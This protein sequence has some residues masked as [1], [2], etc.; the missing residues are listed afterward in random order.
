MLLAATG[1]VLR[2]ACV[3]ALA[4]AAEHESAL[5]AAATA[6]AWVQRLTLVTAFVAVTRWR[7]E[8]TMRAALVLPPLA[9]MAHHAGGQ[10]VLA[11]LHDWP[12]V[13]EE[14]TTQ[15]WQRAAAAADRYGCQLGHS[16]A[17]RHRRH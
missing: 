9:Q 7:Y 4:V 17:C 14:D 11:L 5:Q 16:H 1:I 15:L 3:A 12:E 6:S 2:L 8:R 13:L 10:T